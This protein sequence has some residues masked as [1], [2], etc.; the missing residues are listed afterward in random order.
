MQVEEL[1]ECLTTKRAIQLDSALSVCAFQVANNFHDGFLRTASINMDEAIFEIEDPF[2]IPWRR[3][4]IANIVS[5]EIRIR[6]IEDG[7]QKLT[8]R[9]AEICEKEVYSIACNLEGRQLVIDVEG[10]YDLSIPA[11]FSR[12]TLVWRR[13]GPELAVDA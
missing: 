6:L 7:V 11:D 13:S 9:L 2:F 1:P 3:Y 8:P 10:T 12:S 4:G 5:A